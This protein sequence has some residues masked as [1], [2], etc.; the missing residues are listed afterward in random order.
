MASVP[1]PF[2]LDHYDGL[3]NGGVFE[4]YLSIIGKQWYKRSSSM[5]L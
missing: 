4:I 1:F 3:L 5:V 2:S